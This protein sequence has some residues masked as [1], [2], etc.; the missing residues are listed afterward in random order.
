MKNLN[1]NLVLFKNGSP[2]WIRTSDQTVNSRL[3][4]RWATE[5]YFF[6]KLGDIKHK[7]CKVKYFLM[8][9]L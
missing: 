6:W 5:E 9:R 2:D 4:Y 7:T 3:L 1:A 8:K